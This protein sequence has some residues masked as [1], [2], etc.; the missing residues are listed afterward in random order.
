MVLGASGTAP[1]DRESEEFSRAPHEVNERLF[2]SGGHVVFHLGHVN[3]LTRP[4][5]GNPRGVSL[6]HDA[7]HCDLLFVAGAGRCHAGSGLGRHGTGGC[8][9]LQS[10]SVKVVNFGRLA[11]LASWLALSVRSGGGSDD[12][13]GRGSGLGD[14]C[15]GGSGVGAN[16]RGGGSG[17][18]CAW[19]GHVVRLSPW[20]FGAVLQA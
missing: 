7:I 15:V 18:G 13:S 6:A 8:D 19:R 12:G 5:L 3:P 2:R 17:G 4:V 9:E 14:R 20:R 11:G 10:D 1:L 16:A